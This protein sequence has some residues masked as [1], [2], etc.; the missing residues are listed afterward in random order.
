[1]INSGYTEDDIRKGITALDVVVPED[2]L[3]IADNIHRLMNMESFPA[4]EFTIVRK[5]G[6]TYPAIIHSTPIMQGNQPVGLRGL[7]V[8]IAERKKAEEA[9][10]LKNRNQE[11]LLESV[12]A[13]TASQNV[14]EVLERITSGADQVLNSALCNVYLLEPDGEIIN[15]GCFQQ[16]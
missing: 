15:P 1:M 14:S 4:E 8:D 3:R 5:D 13:L 9:L 7:I 6:T 10:R 2:R 11:H 12:Q 16:S